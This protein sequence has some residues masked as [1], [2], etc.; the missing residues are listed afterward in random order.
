MTWKNSV[1]L[2]TLLLLIGCSTIHYIPNTVKISTTE[3]KEIVKQVIQEQPNELAPIKVE[4]TDQYFKL[5]IMKTNHMDGYT[6]PWTK[7]V[8]FNDIGK[9]RIKQKWRWSK[10]WFVISIM[11]KNKNV[12]CTI[13]TAQENKATSFVDA[14]HVLITNTVS[15]NAMTSFK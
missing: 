11:D 12:K 13:Y 14:F 1:T 7:L 9:I 15:E 8:C 2:Q 3:A 5:H 10:K 6:I 4:V